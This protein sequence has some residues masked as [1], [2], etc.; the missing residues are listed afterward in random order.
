MFKTLGIPGALS[1]L[2]GIS[3]LMCAIP[4]VF[5]WQGDRIRANSKF[6]IAIRERR[7]ANAKKIED[8][9]RRRGSAAKMLS[10]AP[11]GGEKNKTIVGGTH[12]GVGGS[13]SSSGSLATTPG[14]SVGGVTVAGCGSGSSEPTAAHLTVPAVVRVRTEKLGSE[15]GNS[16]DKEMA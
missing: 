14:D 13:S 6:C 3:L 7:E 5:L 16:S 12:A 2:G 11:T 10:M 1:L 8:Q 9:R 15:S 4:F